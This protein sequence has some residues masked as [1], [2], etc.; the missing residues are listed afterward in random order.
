MRKILLVILTLYLASCNKPIPNPELKDP[1]YND[2]N[3]RL[4]EASQ[5]LTAEQNTLKTH[6]KELQEAVPQTGQTIQAQKRVFESQNKITKIEQEIQ[7]LKLKASARKKDAIQSYKKAF[8]KNEIWPEPQEWEQYQKEKK[9]R[10][11]PKEWSVKNR[12]M[13]TGNFSQNNKEEKKTSGH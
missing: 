10:N 5:L 4:T 9:A 11:A 6:E 1:I 12:L 13:E 7:Y 3:V 8:E 2:L